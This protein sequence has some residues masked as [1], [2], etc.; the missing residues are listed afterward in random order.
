VIPVEGLGATGV[1][2]SRLS[3][4]TMLLGRWGRL[5]DQGSID[6]VR[7]A[8]DAG[9]TVFDTGDVY[10]DGDSERLLGAALRGRRDDVLI[11]TKFYGP[12]DD[13]PLHRGTSRRWIMQAVEG[14]LRRLGTD[15]LDVYLQHRPEPT[16]DL[17]E[18]LGA[19]SDLV[20]Q[21]KVRTIGSS[22]FPAE[23]I[24]EAQ[25]TAER[26]GRE[27]PRVEEP[28]YSALTRAIERDVLPT[29]ARY[30]MGVLVWG[31]LGGGWLT[32]AV[33]RGEELPSFGTAP[34]DPRKYDLSLAENQR[35]L[36]A[37]E[38]LAALAA[39]AG[40]PLAHLALAFVLEHPAVTSAIVGPADV[41]ELEALLPA[42]D[43]RLD[44]A[45]LDAID[46][47]VPPGVNLNHRD[48]TYEPPGL[49]S[50]ARRR[51]AR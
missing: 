8:L 17:D 5:D 33:R 43:V 38:A 7:A 45:V 28:P 23:L 47:I 20:H 42:V 48:P 34:R 9:I 44:P 11:V 24:V 21:G 18:T 41:A 1:A 26:R 22:T 31:P 3:L 29:C 10:S 27:R 39:E 37:V 14:S 25:W 46:E 6:L 35:K 32:G 19:L 50:T 12:V 16:T 51:P 49:A 13:D 15:Y 2:A 36:D 40:M 4:G 30:G